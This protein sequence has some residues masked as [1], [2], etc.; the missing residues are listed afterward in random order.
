MNPLLS[1][2]SPELNDSDFALLAHYAKHLGR[3]SK[4]TRFS[5]KSGEK[6]SKQKGHGMEML[7]LRPYQTSDDLRH[8]DWRVTARTGHTHTRLYAQENDHQRLLLMD[9]SPAAYFSTR[10]AFISTRFL[11][12]AGLIAWRS[13]QQGDKLLYSLSFADKTVENFNKS[14]V[15]AMIKQLKSA[16][17]VSNRNQPGNHQLGWY[18]SKVTAK[19]HNKDIIILTDKQDWDSE[20]Q[21]A[22]QQLAKH[23]QVHWVQIF[24]HHSFELPPGQYQ[25]AD[26]SGTVSVNITK[27]S[28]EQAKQDF[29]EQNAIMRQRLAKI[30]IRHQLF[31]ISKP[32]EGI[33]RYLLD[34]GALR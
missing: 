26:S 3:A 31:D 4:A 7:E 18:K 16:S 11:Q 14:S 21:T 32:P 6:R 15:W 23:N 19:A 2:A 8:V 20:Q 10:Y 9:L 28:S 29:F 25:F 22:L 33:A 34:Q 17:Q 1:P 12:L 5:M 13:E 30:G 27:K 24:D